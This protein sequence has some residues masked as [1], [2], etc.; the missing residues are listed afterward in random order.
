MSDQQKKEIGMTNGSLQPCPDSPNC[1]ST[2]AEDE[3]HQISPIFYRDSLI[4]VKKKILATIEKM[5]R[6]TIITVEENYIHVEFRSKIMRFVDDVEFLID[7][8]NKIIHFR[9]AS[10]LGYSDM[11]VNRERMEQFRILFMK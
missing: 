11:G 10:R 5:P 9:S 2:F 7:D 4:E 6:T 1:V 3:E 8:Q